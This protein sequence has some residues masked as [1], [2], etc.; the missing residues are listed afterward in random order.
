MPRFAETSRRRF[1]RSGLNS[2]AQRHGVT[3]SDRSQFLSPLFAR[4]RLDHDPPWPGGGL[5]R[6]RWPRRPRPGRWRR[7][8]PRRGGHRPRARRP[9]SQASARPARRQS[10]EPIGLTASIF[11]GTPGSAGRGAGPG[12]RRAV[13]DDA[14]ADAVPA[15]SGRAGRRRRRRSARGS[16][17]WAAASRRL[18]WIT[19]GPEA[20]DRVE[21]RAV[22]VEEDRAPS[23]RG[24]ARSGRCRGPWVAGD[25]LEPERVSAVDVP[26]R[27]RPL[28]AVE[29]GVGLGLA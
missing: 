18:S 20:P 15:T 22:G 28:D 25:G 3:P 26:R 4:D 5:P 10:P 12:R 19:V 21:C 8:R 11:G 1:S 27:Q 2:S 7:R 24:P 6:G 14:A 23:A 29:Q 13:G 17:R 16:R 9:A